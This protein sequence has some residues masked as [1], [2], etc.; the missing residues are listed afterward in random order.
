MEYTIEIEQQKLRNSG[1]F[2][3]INEVVANKKSLVYMV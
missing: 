1:N 3:F 2:I